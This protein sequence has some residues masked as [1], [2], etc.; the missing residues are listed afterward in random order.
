VPARRQIGAGRPG[1]GSTVLAAA[2][3]ILTEAGK[4]PA[5][6]HRYWTAAESGEG[7]DL[8]LYV[9]DRGLPRTARVTRTAGGY[10]D[11]YDY[12]GWGLL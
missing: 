1:T 11:V 7:C 2:R 8:I 6:V 3:R 9:D 5:K 4:R 10:V 12:E